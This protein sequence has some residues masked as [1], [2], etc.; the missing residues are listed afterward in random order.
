[1]GVGVG[2]D[3]YENLGYNM[4]FLFVSLYYVFFKK[5]IDLYVFINIGYVVIGK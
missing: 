2:V 5:Y 3:R 4:F 1:M